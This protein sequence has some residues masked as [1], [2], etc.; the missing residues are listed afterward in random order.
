MGNDPL[1]RNPSRT[2]QP[3]TLTHS[4]HSTLPSP[5]LPSPSLPYP[6]RSFGRLMKS[7]KASHPNAIG[8]FKAQPDAV[9]NHG[10][11]KIKN[12]IPD[13]LA[14]EHEHYLVGQRKKVS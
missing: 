3:H 5:S 12:A 6:G 4:T 1:E 14:I 8:G 9:V 11:G 10:F 2:I 13:I 7:P